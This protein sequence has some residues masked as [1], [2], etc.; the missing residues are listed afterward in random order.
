MMQHVD[1]PLSKILKPHQKS[2]ICA[3]SAMA[4]ASPRLSNPKNERLMFCSSDDNAKIHQIQSTHDPDGH[5][6]SLKPLLHLLEDIFNRAA[7]TGLASI[8]HQ[9]GA[10]Q[11]K[12]PALDDKALQ[13]F[14]DMLHVLSYTIKKIS[15]E[16]SI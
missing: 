12:F 16:A 11:A 1:K 10:Q 13:G 4:A 9:Q 14:D 8:F 5:E 7:P 2:F 15:C 6:F 3:S